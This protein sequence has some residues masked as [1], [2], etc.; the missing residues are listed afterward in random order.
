MGQVS[1]SLAQDREGSTG[2]HTKD[3]NRSPTRFSS[4]HVSPVVRPPEPVLALART[5]HLLLCAH[6]HDVPVHAVRRMARIFDPMKVVQ[7]IV[8]PARGRAAVPNGRPVAR[9][10]ERAP[11][12]CLD[13]FAQQRLAA[14]TVQG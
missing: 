12:S 3:C 8:E 11:W 7:L 9:D 5:R 1:L 13:A 14:Q 6:T 4:E 2:V 10:L